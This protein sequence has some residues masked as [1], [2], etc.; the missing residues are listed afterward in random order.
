MTDFDKNNCSF[1]KIN[2]QKISN[3]HRTTDRKGLFTQSQKKL[4]SFK[5]HFIFMKKCHK[6][7]FIEKIFL[8]E[9]DEIVYSGFVLKEIR[10]DLNN[11]KLFEEKIKFLKEEQKFSFVKATPYD[12]NFARELESEL[13][14][15]L[16]FFDCLHIALCK[17]GS[18]TLVTR[19]RLLIEKAKKYIF[20][21]TP[22]KVL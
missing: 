18:F 12:Y 13:M 15:E 1:L 5:L 17:R 6:R 20:A 4:N 19:D 10:H 9:E 7:K 2:K 14:F 8:S 3:T 22:E 21:D 16:S 11:E